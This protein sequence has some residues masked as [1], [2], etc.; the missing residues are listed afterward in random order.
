MQSWFNI[1]K[2]ISVIHHVNRLKKKNHMMISVD[3][4]NAFDKMQHPFMIFKMLNKLGREGVFFDLIKVIYKK[5]TANITSN[6]ERLNLFFPKIRNKIKDVCSHHSYSTL[7][8]K[9]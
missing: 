3:T 7:Y 9:S 1:Q 8:W 2:S 4:D 5:P 6:R